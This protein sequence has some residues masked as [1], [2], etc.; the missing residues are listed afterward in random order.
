MKRTNRQSGFVD[1]LELVAMVMFMLSIFAVFMHVFSDGDKK[2]DQ[3]V[4]ES[5]ETD[6][7]EEPESIASRVE[8]G[9][10]ARKKEVAREQ[11]S[12]KDGTSLN[13]ETVE[14]KSSKPFKPNPFK[15]GSYK[16]KY[17]RKK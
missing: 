3:Q 12:V 10:L 2:D 6:V 1:L 13:G 4:S 17:K 5:A 8:R 14:V 7:V 9:K 15:Q 11:E 16:R